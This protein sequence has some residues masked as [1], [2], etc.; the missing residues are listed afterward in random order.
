MHPRRTSR[1][2]CLRRRHAEC[3]SCDSF[4]VRNAARR[5]GSSTRTVKRGPSGRRTRRAVSRPSK[6]PAAAKPRAHG[7]SRWRHDAS[8]SAERTGLPWQS[9][10]ADSWTNPWSGGSSVARRKRRPRS[11]WTAR[12]SWRRSSR[13]SLRLASRGTNPAEI[14]LLEDDPQSGNVT[15]ACL[16]V[17]ARAKLEADLETFGFDRDTETKLAALFDEE[18]FPPIRVR[19]HLVRA[20]GLPAATETGEDTLTRAPRLV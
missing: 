7:T 15:Y 5:R 10:P 16:T 12:C 18:L 17:T 1:P 14:I 6:Q 8:R 3:R 2:P 4:T 9:V 11:N 19:R 20:D 13:R